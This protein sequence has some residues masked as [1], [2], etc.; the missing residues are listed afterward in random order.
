MLPHEDQMSHPHHP[1]ASSSAVGNKDWTSYSS[2]ATSGKDAK[3]RME[4]I[5]E[6]FQ[7][8]GTRLSHLGMQI[9]CTGYEETKW[10]LFTLSDLISSI[11]L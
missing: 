5:N 8:S 1:H 3:T 7:G 11:Q 4:E 9:S 10:A 2:W 6:G